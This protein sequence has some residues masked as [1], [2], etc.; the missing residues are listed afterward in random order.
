[1]RGRPPGIV[2]LAVPKAGIAS[3][4][5]GAGVAPTGSATTQLLIFFARRITRRSSEATD[6]Q[7]AMTTAGLDSWKTRRRPLRQRWMDQPGSGRHDSGGTGRCGEQLLA[8]RRRAANH[9]PERLPVAATEHSPGT[10]T[11]RAIGLQRVTAD[12]TAGFDPSNRPATANGPDHHGEAV[13]QICHIC[14]SSTASHRGC[15]NLGTQAA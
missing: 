6:S 9:A 1:M 13:C 8:L 2:S 10:G 11:Y 5:I 4:R 7:A 3:S 15:A 12:L 14:Q